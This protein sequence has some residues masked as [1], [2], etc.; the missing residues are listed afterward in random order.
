MKKLLIII[1]T[2]LLVTACSNNDPANETTQEVTAEDVAIEANDE[3]NEVVDEYRESTD[4]LKAELQEQTLNAI[5][6]DYDETY[7]VFEIEEALKLEEVISEM[8]KIDINI[9]YNM[10]NDLLEGLT[11]E[12]MEVYGDFIDEIIDLE[13]AI[14]D[15]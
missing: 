14:S 13:D 6:N 1:A 5:L 11:D 2:L 4:D 12:Q 3:M 9:A 10:K 7:D 8:A 15:M